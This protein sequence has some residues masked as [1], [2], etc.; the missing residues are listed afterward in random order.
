MNAQ[1]KII[2][3][4]PDMNSQGGMSSVIK[5]YSSS[6]LLD[7][8]VIYL[9]A[10]KDGNFLFKIIFFFIFLIKYIFILIRIRHIKLIHIHV[11][12]KGSF[13]RK[14]IVFKI[15]KLFHK[16]IIFNVHPIDFVNFYNKVNIVIQKMIT[17]ALNKSDL[18]LVLSGTIKSEVANICQNRNIKILYNPVIV[19]E[20]RYKESETINVLFLGKLCKEKGVYDIIEAS[21]LVKSPN[22]KINLYGD[23][24]IEEFEKLIKE[25]NLQEKIKIMGWISGR[26]KD[27]ALN[28]SDIFILPSYSEGLPMSILEAMAIGLPIISTPVGGIPE[29]VEDGADGFLVS[30]GDYNAL[31]EKIDSLA[32][33]K[34]QREQ[35][36]QRGYEIAREKF[37]VNVIISQLKEIYNELLESA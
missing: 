9:S 36:G 32:S 4:G 8:D 34:P 5:L 28:N 2:M 7:N 24:D 17:E 21:K 25:N 15:A 29:A 23:G 31:A 27:E 35:M 14:Y 33:N 13:F 12:I 20:F 1:P 18:I 6:E 37:D 3:I 22:I 26:E 19:K 16:K 30:P 11:A 10:Y